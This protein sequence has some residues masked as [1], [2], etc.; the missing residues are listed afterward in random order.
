MSGDGHRRRRPGPRPL[1]RARGASRWLPP[2][3][4]VGR[5][6]ATP[7]SDP[8]GS[9]RRSVD[10]EDDVDAGVSADGEPAPATERVEPAL[11]R[12]AIRVLED[13]DLVEVPFVG[14]GDAVRHGPAFAPEREFLERS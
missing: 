2:R 6:A 13:P 5:G 3:T 14:I 8:P 7:S 1:R 12:L 10:L 4:G 11:S 9:T